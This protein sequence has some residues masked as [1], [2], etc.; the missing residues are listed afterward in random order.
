MYL[1]TRTQP[2]P[3]RLSL[4]ASKLGLSFLF[5][6]PPQQ[7]PTQPSPPLERARTR[8]LSPPFSPRASNPYSNANWNDINPIIPQIPPSSNPRGELIFSSRVPASFREAYERYRDSFERKRQ[9]G[10]NDTKATANSGVAKS[11][12]GRL[13]HPFGRTPSDTAFGVGT[14]GVETPTARA[15]VPFP[16]QGMMRGR[17]STNTPSG[18]RKSSPAPGSLGK[19]GSKRGAKGRISRQGTPLLEIVE[20]LGA[21]ISP[22]GSNPGNEG[23]GSQEGLGDRSGEVA[24]M[25]DPSTLVEVPSL[26]LVSG[27]EGP[28]RRRPARGR[29]GSVGV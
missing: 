7:S 25:M 20:A 16:N 22:P 26:G 8:S 15:E 11:I 21:G 10:E 13:R 1:N 3:S 6:S 19:K 27:I 28:V 9:G 23:I 14:P 4:F 12:L 24:G 2:L 18:S 5:P 17:T 29:K